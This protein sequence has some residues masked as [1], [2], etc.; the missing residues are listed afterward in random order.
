MQAGQSKRAVPSTASEEI[1]PVKVWCNF[2]KHSA[3]IACI[4]SH[5][6]TD[7]PFG[8]SGRA[9]KWGTAAKRLETSLPM[10]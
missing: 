10:D 3:A 4:N 2:M 9:L 6:I 1:R 7:H 5:H 8:S